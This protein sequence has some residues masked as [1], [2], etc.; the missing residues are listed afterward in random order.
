M[1][2]ILA[3]YERWA[4]ALSEEA[5]VRSKRAWKLG[6]QAVEHLERGLGRLLAARRARRTHLERRSNVVAS[7]NVGTPNSS[8]VVVANQRT[9]VRQAGDRTAAEENNG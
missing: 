2:T 5:T 8:R 6:L 9:E 1:G 4:Y 7:V 3:S